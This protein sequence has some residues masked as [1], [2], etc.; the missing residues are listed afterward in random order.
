MKRPLFLLCVII[1]IVFGILNISGVF[2]AEKNTYQSSQEEV[3]T[4]FFTR[5]L[6]TSK[7][8]WEKRVYEV[9]PEQE[10]GILCDLL[11]GD[12]SAL[13]DNV[14]DLYTRNGIAHILSISGLHISILGLGLYMLLRR[15][16]IPL[17][18]AAA[19]AGLFPHEYG[20]C[21]PV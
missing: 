7:Q 2:S 4:N 20:K 1:L 15:A 18:S 11:L 14:K 3:G 8:R 10:G 17:A 16:G 19:A 5:A 9:F 12:R 13:P 21:R 6:E